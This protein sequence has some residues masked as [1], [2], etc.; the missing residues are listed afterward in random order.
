MWKTSIAALLLG[1]SLLAHA[2]QRPGQQAVQW[3]LQVLKDGQQIDSFEGTTTV[4]QARTDT[5]HQVIQHNVGC[6]DQP[7][8]SIDLSR[9]ITLSPLRVDPQGVMLSID[10]QE[11]LESDSAQRTD[12]GC[13][14]PPQPR[15]VNA[16]HPGLVV[17]PDQWASWTIV[18]SNPNLVY[19][20]HANVVNNGANGNGAMNGNGGAAGG[21]ANSPASD[22]A[23]G[24]ASGTTIAVP[25]GKS[26]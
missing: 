8:G 23:A 17:P 5:H 19:R 13:K 14:L 3:Q 10:T 20:V 22:T 18:A 25:P 24:T 4:G 2:Q 11:T 16:S 26:N 12:I 15:Q 21:I 1:A 7:A 6:K 9:T